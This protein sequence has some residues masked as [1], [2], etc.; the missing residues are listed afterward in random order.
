MTDQILM[1]ILNSTDDLPEVKLSLFFSN[2][3]ILNKVVQF[4][5]RSQL[6]NDEDI[7]GGI[8]Y[9]IK[10]DD[11]GVVDELENLDLSFDL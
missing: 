8:E 6:H 1:H 5:F 2:F 9:F 11:I 7:I 4:S 3:V 10:L